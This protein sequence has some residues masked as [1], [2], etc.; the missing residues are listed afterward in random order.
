L[1]KRRLPEK[2]G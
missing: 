2:G 1:K